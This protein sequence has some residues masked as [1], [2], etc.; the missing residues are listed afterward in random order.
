MSVDYHYVGV[1]KWEIT[2]ERGGVRLQVVGDYGGKR[3]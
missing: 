2:K 1:S 3:W